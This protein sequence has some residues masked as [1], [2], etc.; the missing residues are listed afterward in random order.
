MPLAFY[1][2][3]LFIDVDDASFDSLNQK[4]GLSAE[5]R[6]QRRKTSTNFRFA[7]ISANQPREIPCPITQ[8]R[9]SFRIISNAIDFLRE[10]FCQ[11]ERLWHFPRL[12]S[13]K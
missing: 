9:L 2:E 13:F 1:L 5:L 10:L 3:P 6:T 11:L 4:R 7:G 12:A 8:N